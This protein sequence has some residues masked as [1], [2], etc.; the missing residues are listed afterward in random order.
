MAKKR[1]EYWSAQSSGYVPSPGGSTTTSISNQVPQSQPQT[2][3]NTLTT[4][5]PVNSFDMAPLQTA[6]PQTPTENS[7]GL[8]GPKPPAPTRVRALY[9]F[10]ATEEGELELKKGD[11]VK[12]IDSAYKDW[13]RGEGKG[14]RTG[15]FPVTYV[16][17]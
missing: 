1:Q 9:D 5:S 6:L 2:R 13:W 3:S 16:V 10:E 11:I 7:A 8:T 14:G 17:S 12:V 4:S 15:I